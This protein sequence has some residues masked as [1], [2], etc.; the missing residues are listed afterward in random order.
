MRGRVTWR[1]AWVG[2]KYPEQ[3]MWLAVAPPARGMLPVCPDVIAELDHID[4]V[5]LNSS[6]TKLRRAQDD[7]L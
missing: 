6:Q 1:S 2:L 3:V 7:R 5:M 4:R